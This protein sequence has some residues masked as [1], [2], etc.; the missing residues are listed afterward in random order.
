MLFLIYNYFVNNSKSLTLCWDQQ[1]GAQD[2]LK[3]GRHPLY[4]PSILKKMDRLPKKVPV[5]VKLAGYPPKL[6]HRDYS[7]QG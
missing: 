7:S 5:T 2:S 1:N 4:K 6:A 3:I